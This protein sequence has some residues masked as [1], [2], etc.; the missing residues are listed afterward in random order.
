MLYCECTVEMVVVDFPGLYIHTTIKLIVIK[1]PLKAQE[2][3]VKGISPESLSGEQEI[4]V[5]EIKLIAR[6][7]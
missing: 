1:V 4:S 7:F 2:A 5:G 3:C 6:V